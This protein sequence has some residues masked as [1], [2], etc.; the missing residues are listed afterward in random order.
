MERPSHTITT[1]QLDTGPR[2]FAVMGLS[3]GVQLGLLSLF[4][5]GIV[6]KVIAPPP[7][8]HFTPTEKAVLPKTPPPPEPV[9]G[10]P[11]LPVIAAPLVRTFDPSPGGGITGTTEPLRVAPPVVPPQTKPVATVPDREASSIKETLAAVPYP[12][13]ER[14]LGMEGRVVLRLTV[15]ASGKVGKTEIV[16][17]SGRPALDRAAQDWIPA[18]WAYRPAIRDGVAVESQVLAAV[19]FTLTNP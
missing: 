15:L 7:P 12:P 16:T 18:R 3:V 6:T 5:V 13:M 14:R 2:R 4:L 1:L 10:K 19:N 11:R 8:M 17:S 9:I